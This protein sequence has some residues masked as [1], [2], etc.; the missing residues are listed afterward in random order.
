MKIQRVSFKDKNK[1]SSNPEQRTL[2]DVDINEIKN[3]L[4]ITIDKVNTLENGS[5]GSSGDG[6]TDANLENYYTKDEI[7]QLI[8]KEQDQF[9]SKQYIS[10]LQSNLNSLINKIESIK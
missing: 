10:S 3:Q 6:D 7:E 9:I 5:G 4:N 1:Y 8:D 2:T